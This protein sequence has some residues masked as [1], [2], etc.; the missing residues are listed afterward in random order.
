MAF[1][2]HKLL[3]FGERVWH[4]APKQ[5]F[6]GLYPLV[7]SDDL[8]EFLQKCQSALLPNGL[9]CLKENIATKRSVTDKADSSITRYMYGPF[10]SLGLL[11]GCLEIT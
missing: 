1:N 3:V 10:C 2:E 11:T 4:E 6:D 7:S 9:I 8:I 5:N